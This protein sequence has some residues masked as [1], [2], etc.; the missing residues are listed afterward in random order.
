VPDNFISGNEGYVKLGA[1]AYTFGEWQFPVEGGTRKFFAFGSDFQK[2]LPGGKSA[3]VTV[4]GPYNA[5]NM[6]LVVGDVYEMH[7]GWAAGVELVV[8]ARLD[9]VD[10][11]NK[12]GQGGEPGGQI[13]CTFESEGAFGIS[14]T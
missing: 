4:K 3:Q 7:L 5:G 11:G 12:I 13:S 8:S 1:T 14:F 6:A 9:K 10:F 2:T